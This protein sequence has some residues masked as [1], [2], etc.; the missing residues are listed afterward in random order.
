[1]PILEESEINVSSANILIVD[2]TPANIDILWKMLETEGYNISGVPNGR[3]ALGL[4][5]NSQPCLIL[6]DVMMPDM[7]G[8]EVCRRLKANPLTAHIPIIFITAR[9]EP[10]DIVKA[11]SAGGNDYISKPFYQEEVKSRILT[12]LRLRK[13][14]NE[15][16]KLI[17]ALSEK[18]PD[19]LNRY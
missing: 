9:S 15:N 13:L 5:L 18:N 4:A 12:R 1:M 3:I 11:F 17:E 6:L 16:K 7:D 19:T 8:Y 2:D 10:A 14:L